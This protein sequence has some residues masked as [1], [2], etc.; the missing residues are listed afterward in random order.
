VE[1]FKLLERTLAWSLAGAR[2][3]SSRRTPSPFRAGAGLVLARQPATRRGDVEE[4]REWDGPQGDDRVGA[5]I[6]AAFAIGI[7]L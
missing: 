3:A 7:R 6:P 4:D 1:L 5:P 2:D